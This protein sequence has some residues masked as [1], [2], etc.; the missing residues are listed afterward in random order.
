L[1]IANL[2]PTKYETLIRLWKQLIDKDF[3][4]KEVF[5]RA[6]N[7]SSSSRNENFE[8]D[9]LENQSFWLEGFWEDN[10]GATLP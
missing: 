2:Q 3:P 1:V 9:E 10:C 8:N 5:G 4:K 7:L 6:E